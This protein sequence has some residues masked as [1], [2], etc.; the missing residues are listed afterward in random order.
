MSSPC[1]ES[2]GPPR[3]ELETVV[4]WPAVAG[5]VFVP[6]TETEQPARHLDEKGATARREERIPNY[7][8]RDAVLLVLRQLTGKDA[9]TQAA[10]WAR[11]IAQDR[12]AT[13][14]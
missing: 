2:D 10:S 4:R 3:T 11:L 14:H 12:A 7:P 1:Q 13:K 5:L 8:Q 6:L 9:G